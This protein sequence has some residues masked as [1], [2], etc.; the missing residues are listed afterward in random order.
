MDSAQLE[1]LREPP[2]AAAL[3]EWGIELP[4]PTEQA[5][6][7][8]ARGAD[9]HDLFLRPETGP[10]V[11]SLWTQGRYE[12]DATVRVRKLAEVAGMEFQRSAA[13]GAAVDHLG[14]LLLLWSATDGHA[15]AVAD[16]IAAAHLEWGLAGMARIESTGGFYGAVA[17]AAADLV[18]AIL[19][20]SPLTR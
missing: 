6:W 5:S 13:R 12:G 20:A 19:A 14:S 9:Y 11:Q 18:R 10:L 15:Q 2:L 1:R 8:E 17:A 4:P 16:E 7:I 3:G